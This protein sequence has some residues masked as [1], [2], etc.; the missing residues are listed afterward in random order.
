MNLGASAFWH[1]GEDALETLMAPY[2]GL[3]TKRAGHSNRHPFL[4][5][6]MRNS[7]V[8]PEWE[9]WRGWRNI[10]GRGQETAVGSGGPMGGSMS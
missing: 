9:T 3:I 2:G 7:T 6:H 10:M 8:E 5:R 4:E 1:T